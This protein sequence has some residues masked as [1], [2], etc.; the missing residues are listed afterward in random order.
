MGFRL[1]YQTFPRAA[2][3]HPRAATDCAEYCPVVAHRLVDCLPSRDERIRRKES[4]L[5]CKNRGGGVQ[6]TPL[7][8]SFSESSAVVG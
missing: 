6:E 4:M 8:R 1:Y 7:G 2:V 5:K 3:Q